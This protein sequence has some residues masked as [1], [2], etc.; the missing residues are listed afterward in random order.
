MTST[1]TTTDDD[2]V[3]DDADTTHTDMKK[4]EIETVMWHLGAKSIRISSVVD[5]SL[6]YSI[7]FLLCVCWKYLEVVFRDRQRPAITAKYVKKFKWNKKGEWSVNGNKLSFV[8]KIHRSS[9]NLTPSFIF[10]QTLFF[11]PFFLLVYGKPTACHLE[12]F[13]F[14]TNIYF[15][16]VFFF[17]NKQQFNLFCRLLHLFV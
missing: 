2:D 11:L 16:Q 14:W 17:S 10:T 13:S 12:I 9:Y 15:S 6:I 5:I 8:S 7:Q 1:T 3:D 4:S